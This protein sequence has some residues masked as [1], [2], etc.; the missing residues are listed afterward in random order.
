[1]HRAI[2]VAG[3]DVGGISETRRD[4]LRGESARPKVTSLWYAAASCAVDIT[5][6]RLSHAFL[7]H[8]CISS[9]VVGSIPIRAIARTQSLSSSEQDDLKKRES[10]EQLHDVMKTTHGAPASTKD[11]RR[12]AISLLQSTSEHIDMGVASGET[13]PCSFNTSGDA[14]R[15]S[16][17]ESIDERR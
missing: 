6:A 5:R 16:I 9:D 10:R 17:A 1:M 11:M 14:P 15:R 8:D 4:W 13:K 2:L 12:M 3:E 7:T